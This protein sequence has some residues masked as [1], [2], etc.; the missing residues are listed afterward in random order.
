MRG[1]IAELLGAGD[2]AEALA[3]PRAKLVL[4]W[5]TILWERVWPAVW[6]AIGVFGQLIWVDTETG[7]VIAMQS[8]WPEPVDRVRQD[9]RWAVV[10]AISRA[11]GPR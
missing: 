4:V 8:A 1:R 9:H 6:P 2:A 10:E 3:I 5:L 11:I 7:V